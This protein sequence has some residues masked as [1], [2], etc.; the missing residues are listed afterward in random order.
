MRARRR[1]TPPSFHAVFS[2]G[3]PRTFLPVCLPAAACAPMAC[4]ATMTAGRRARLQIM[5]RAL[6]ATPPTNARLP[7]DEA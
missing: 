7:H 3:L 2:S 4:T 6:A 1:C 5:A